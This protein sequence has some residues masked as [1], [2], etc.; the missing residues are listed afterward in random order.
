MAKE[1][2]DREAALEALSSPFT[3][4]ALSMDEL[5]GMRLAQEMERV[6]IAHI[7]AADVVEVRRGKWVYGH[8]PDTGEPDIKAWTCSLCGEKYPWQPHYCPNCG[9]KMEGDGE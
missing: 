7:P 3:M 2:I 8:D 1:Y 5:K 4:R 6:V 9:A